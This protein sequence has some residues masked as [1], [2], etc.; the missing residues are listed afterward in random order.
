[1][2]TE[3]ENNFV[4]GFKCVFFFALWFLA[5][6]LLL[7]TFLEPRANAYT[8]QEAIRT[9]VGEA[10]NQG[11]KGMICVGEVIRQNS[12]LRGFYGLHASHSL[13]EPARIWA[14][15]K[16]AWISSKN[17]N[18]TNHANHFENIH[19]FGEPYWVK[20]CVLTFEYRDH[21]FYREVK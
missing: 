5:M 1:M 11:F 12:S 9:I 15:A 6:F 17:T 4:E 14:L 13:K 8:D 10:S 18:F 16:Q 20:R 3:K 2:L 21:K 7:A 19:A